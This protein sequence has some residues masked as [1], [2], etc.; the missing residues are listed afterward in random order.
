MLEPSISGPAGISG[1]Y[2]A[3]VEISLWDSVEE[4]LVNFAA[5]ELPSCSNQ[6]L[7]VITSCSVV[8]G[9]PSLVRVEDSFP[10]MP[11]DLHNTMKVRGRNYVQKNVSIKRP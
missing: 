4:T 7:A 5:L 8:E 11:P 6:M 1:V 10:G 2:F 9:A 3:R